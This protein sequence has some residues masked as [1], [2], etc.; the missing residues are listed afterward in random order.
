MQTGVNGAGRESEY[1]AVLQT[2]DVL[3]RP[4]SLSHEKEYS[5]IGDEMEEEARG[6]Y[7]RLLGRNLEQLVER[8]FA[9]HYRV[10]YDHKTADP[11][12]II[13][14]I[15]GGKQADNLSFV[16]LAIVRTTDTEERL[17]L[18]SEIE[19]HKHTPKRLLGD[20]AAIVMADSVLVEGREHPL[21]NLIVVLGFV[22]KRN[23][24]T[25]PRA[26]KYVAKFES[27][28]REGIGGGRGIKFIVINADDGVL[29]V[30][31]VE[32]RIKSFLHEGLNP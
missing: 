20:I 21:T 16:D 8:E 1:L 25:G 19:E 2:Q 12:R 5:G 10:Y 4:N 23:G 11:D 26:E 9:G 3:S 7:T 32:E 31:E 24:R 17:C 6:R 18:I 15:G 22:T 30:K 27:A 29:L 13:T 14:Q 28:M